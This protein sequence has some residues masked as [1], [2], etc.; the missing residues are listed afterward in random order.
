MQQRLD[1][2]QV[3]VGDGAHQ[4]V[5]L[6]AGVLDVGFQLDTAGVDGIADEHAVFLPEVGD[7]QGEDQQGENRGDR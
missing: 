7:G 2:A 6:W 1:G 4:R 5:L 3:A